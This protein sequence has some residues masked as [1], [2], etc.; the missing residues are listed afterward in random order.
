MNWLEIAGANFDERALACSA[1]GSSARANLR[2]LFG[3]FNSDS[4]VE[5]AIEI[6]PK[7]VEKLHRLKTQPNVRT[8]RCVIPLPFVIKSIIVAVIILGLGWVFFLQKQHEKK[9]AL[10]LKKRQEEAFVKA[11]ATPSPANFSLKDV[12]ERSQMVAPTPKP[13]PT[14][15]LPKPTPML[16]PSP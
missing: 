5:R 3:R 12:L 4:D 14:P 7:V 10:E 16:R 1:T 9:E 8:L 2:F 11:H 13:K 15:M 6:V